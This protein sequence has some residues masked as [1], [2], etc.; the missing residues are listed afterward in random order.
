[1]KNKFNSNKIA[2]PYLPKCFEF[3]NSIGDF[4]LDAAALR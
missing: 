3:S 2:P 1:M 4:M